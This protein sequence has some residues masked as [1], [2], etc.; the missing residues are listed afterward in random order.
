MNLYE[1]K[2]TTIDGKEVSLENYK[3]KVL[4]IVNIASKCGFTP[5]LEDLQKL[6]NEYKSQELEVIGFPCN[7]FKEQSPG[8][9]SD[10]NNFCKLNYGVTFTLSEKIDVKGVNAHPLF[11]YLVGQAPFKGFDMTNFSDRLIHSIVTETSPESLIDSSI[12]WNFTKF[13]IGK[14]GTVLNRFEPRVEPMDMLPAIKEA[15]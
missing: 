7:Q 11:T 13:L 4:L 10:L 15:L 8:S 14:D 9:N 2:F 1:F 3:G 5:Q 6:Y 12:K